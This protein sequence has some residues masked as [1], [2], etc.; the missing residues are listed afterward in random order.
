MAT[1][2]PLM[3]DFEEFREPFVGGGSVFFHARQTHPEKRFWINDLYDEL[4]HFWKAAQ[5]QNPALIR[6]VLKWRDEFADGKSLHRFLTDNIRQMGALEKAA[7]FFILN[8]ITFS[9]TSESGG[10][11]EQAFQKRF[12]PSSIERLGKTEPVLANARITNLDYQA[13]V[14]E[15]GDGVFIFLDPPYYSA[16]ASALYGKN[17]NLHRQFDH[18]RFAEVM[19]TCRHRWLITLDDH[20]LIR[21]LFGFAHIFEWKLT[22]GMRNITPTSD[23]RANEIFISNFL[24]DLRFE[25]KRT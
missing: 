24:H 25:I 20:P 21:E 6:Q 16:T 10:Y 9:G 14:E 5:S 17:G 12:T 1:I 15:K 7:A 18:I 23:Q 3:P 2:A 4:Y 8:R 11:S 22:Y 19:K 13:V